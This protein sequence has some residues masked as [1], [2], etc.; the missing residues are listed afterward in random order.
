MTNP[1]IDHCPICGDGCLHEI[2]YD[3]E[4]EH[5]GQFGLVHL[6]ISKCDTCQSEVPT[7]A[8]LLFNKRAVVEFEKRVEKRLVG[9]EIRAIRKTLLLTQ[10]EAAQVFGGGKNAF[11]KYEA[12]DITQS[13]S[14]DKLIRLCHEVPEARQWLMKNSSLEKQK[15]AANVPEDM[16]IVSTYLDFDFPAIP[17][18]ATDKSARATHISNSSKSGFWRLMTTKS[19]GIIRSEKTDTKF[20][21][22][23]EQL[24]QD[25]IHHYGNHLADRL[26]IQG[27]I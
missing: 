16:F 26:A 21:F 22:E 5:N 17:K 8:Q 7:D 3:H 6:K 4:F 10:S 9:S 23:R 2:G 15:S 11:A 1:R 18:F 24:A 12:N 20:L 19:S 25:D 27:S 14:M 13:E